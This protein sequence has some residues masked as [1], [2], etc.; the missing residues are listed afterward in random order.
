M[1]G[2]R[3]GGRHQEE[4]PATA[5]ELTVRTAE[6]EN[7][8]LRWLLLD[9]NRSLIIVLLSV[10]VFLA[11]LGLGLAGIIGV[12]EPGP[13]SGAF[14]SALTGVFALVTITVSINQLVL[15]R[16]LGSPGDIR[17]RVESVQRFRGD[18]EEMHPQVA[19]SPS[20]PMGF[21]S[22][23]TE[24]VRGRAL[25]L[26]ETYGA[27]HDPQQR[28]QVDELTA[29]VV[30]LANHVDRNVGEDNRRLYPILSPI[31]NNSYSGHLNTLRYVE[32]AADDLAPDE[33][34]A[35]DDLAEALELINLT[36][37]YFKTLYIHEELS[38]VSQRILLTGIPAGVLSFAAILVYAGGLPS[39]VGALPLLVVMS[40]AVSLVFVPLSILFAYG[41]RLATVAARTTTFG[42]FT[43]IEEMP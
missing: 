19:T 37:H 14:A 18:V 7:A 22:V 2:K 21:L 27:D 24:A 35:I 17:D 30:D 33:R 29:T 6:R 11:F 28:A 36:R 9:G 34:E 31:L 1:A 32:T 43:P 23:V 42:A 38:T 4:E 25:H 40:A 8:V 10:G 3:G 16:V 13:V 39:T 12:T 26:R 20:N 15:S 41:L 5:E